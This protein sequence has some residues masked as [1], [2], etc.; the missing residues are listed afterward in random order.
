[1]Y[2]L[3]LLFT[4]VDVAQ[5]GYMIGI[6]AGTACYLG[7]ISSNY[8]FTEQGNLVPQITNV[9]RIPAWCWCISE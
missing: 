8:D 5:A 3:T 4:T 6:G 9:Y 1:M 2:R 7:P